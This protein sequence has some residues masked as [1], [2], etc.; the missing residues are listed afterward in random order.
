MDDKTPQSICVSL[1]MAKKLKEAGWEQAG[2][3]FWYE[4]HDE[5][6]WSLCDGH[7]CSGEPDEDLICAPTAEEI[8]RELPS[9]IE[10]RAQVDGIL[11]KRVLKIIP[12]ST[13]EWDISYESI[14]NQVNPS[15]AGAAASIWIYLKENSLLPS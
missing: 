7:D 9:V 14:M 10:Y 12:T 13:N 15:L 2:G 8:L 3:W 11:K 5:N 6:E 4:R 1:D